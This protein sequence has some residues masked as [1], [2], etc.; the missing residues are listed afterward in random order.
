MRATKAARECGEEALR[1]LQ[2]IGDERGVLRA[3]KLLARTALEDGRPEEAAEGFAQ[4]VRGAEALGD[5][6]MRTEAYLGLA[7]ARLAQGRMR[8][9]FRA[10]EEARRDLALAAQSP[11]ALEWDAL[12]L[13]RSIRRRQFAEVPGG[14]KKLKAGLRRWDTRRLTAECLALCG[15]EL[16]RHNRLAEAAPVREDALEAAAQPDAVAW[17]EQFLAT[18][19]TVDVRQWITSLVTEVHGRTKVEGSSWT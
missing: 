4:V 8:G 11:V 10:L 17:T 12:D 16:V 9:L 18:A 7:R 15:F 2:E 1:Q 6:T 19:R 3:Q 13:V 5:E 14:I